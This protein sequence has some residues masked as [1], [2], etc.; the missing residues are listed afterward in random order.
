MDYS[1]KEAIVYKLENTVVGYNSMNRVSRL[2][3]QTKSGFTESK[4]EA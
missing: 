1:E 4:L 2:P 3:V